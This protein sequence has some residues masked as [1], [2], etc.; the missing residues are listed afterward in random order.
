MT[1]KRPIALY[2]GAFEELRSG[3]TLTGV[4]AAACFRAHKNG[5][6][7][8]SISSATWTKLTFGS[9]AFDVGG[10]FDTTNARWTPPAG[11]VRLSA[12]AHLLSGTVDDAYA[13]IAIYKNGSALV[14]KV[15]VVKG[16]KDQAFDITVNDVAS[17]SDYYEA[18]VNFGGTGNKAVSG[19]SMWT[20][21]CGEQV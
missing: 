18:Y 4:A 1:A 19:N 13:Y 12:Q 9:E 5:T 7:Q 11:P 8:S 6:D 20:F 15:R 2:A 17:G 14:Q 16:T 10:H 21:F 3:D